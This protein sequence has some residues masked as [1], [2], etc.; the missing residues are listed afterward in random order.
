MCDLEPV[1]EDSLADVL[2]KFYCSLCKKDGCEYKRCG[3]IAA[4]SAIQRHLDDLGRRISLRS[5]KFV[6]AN[7]VLD[8]YLKDK[9]KDG[10]EEAVQHKASVSEED[11]KRLKDYFADAATSLKAKERRT[12]TSFVFH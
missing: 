12:L 2:E 11:W 5:E 3:Y 7:K 10:R 8:V 4:R 1:D 6:R 9:K